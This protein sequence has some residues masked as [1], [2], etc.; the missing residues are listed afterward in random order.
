MTELPKDT[1]LKHSDFIINVLKEMQIETVI[2]KD[3]AYDLTKNES[4]FV[5]SVAT[6][7]EAIFTHLTGL[8]ESDAWIKIGDSALKE[9][10]ALGLFLLVE[11]LQYAK[12]KQDEANKSVLNINCLSVIN[13]NYLLDRFLDN[14]APRSNGQPLTPRSIDLDDQSFSH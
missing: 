11:S 8:P 9:E 14:I 2:Y 6:H 10:S 12:S 4:G 3:T 13:D 5:H 1:S 7:A